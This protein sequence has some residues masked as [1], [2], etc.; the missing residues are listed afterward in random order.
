VSGSSATG[1]TATVTAAGDIATAL[2]LTKKTVRNNVSNIFAK[3]HVA[4]RASAVAKARDAG[5]GA[6]QSQRPH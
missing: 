6:S 2:G 4:D 3:L 1:P 5:L